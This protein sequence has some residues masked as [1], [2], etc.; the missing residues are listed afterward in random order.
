MR[1]FV[2]YSRSDAEF[3]GAL[4]RRL[5]ADGHDVWLDTE[6]IRGSEQWRA[7]IVEGVRRAEA[8]LLV[9]SP[10]SMASEYVAREVTLAA[11]EKR[12]IVPLLLEPAAMSGNIRFELAGVQQIS[13]DGVPFESA[14]EKLR[15]I[16]GGLDQQRSATSPV[17][18]RRRAAQSGRHWRRR[19]VAFAGSIGL[20][21]VA[22]LLSNRLIGGESHGAS[23]GRSSTGAV[24]DEVALHARVWFSGF[25]IA[26]DRASYDEDAHQVT[27]RTRFT[28]DQPGDAD[29]ANIV[30]R[31]D[32]AL[33][34]SGGRGQAFCESCV[35]LP[36]GT[37]I[38]SALTFTVGDGF[39]FEDAALVFGGPRQH[40]ATIPLHGQAAESGRPRHYDITGVIHDG[41]GTT[42]RVEGV[43]VVPAA[44]DGP[45]DKL[46]F[47]P[48]AKDEVSVVV[49]GTA[50]LTA[51][52][53]GG[54]NFG[55]A[56]LVLPN[57]VRIN[58]SSLSSYWYALYPHRPVHG[59][60]VCFVVPSPARGRY[61]FVA[62][63]AKVDPDPR[64][65]T[66]ALH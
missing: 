53:P 36:P 13:F 45:P 10:R 1:L 55:D 42:F 27:V 7:S 58:S 66:I 5:E 35:S 8:V 44:C 57:G 3:V 54:V 63:A 15:D 46:T 28:N 52:N 14:I 12:R 21:V 24:A 37:T 64:G 6:D 11:E 9:V 61:R 22:A 50:V 33:E 31:A 41:K 32:A 48:A 65:L 4:V 16:L 49:R 34:W 38:R 29:P 51:D 17:L 19:L 62:T 2:S 25:K 30:Y 47:A 60:E 56:Y 39:R 23:K 43:E 40:H 26:V 20:V 59:V 18:P